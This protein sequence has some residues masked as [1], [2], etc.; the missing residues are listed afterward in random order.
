MNEGSRWDIVQRKLVLAVVLGVLVENALR[1]RN[2]KEATERGFL[3]S[4]FECWPCLK[5]NSAISD[6]IL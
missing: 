4:F 6:L 5:W 2:M 1:K 3:S